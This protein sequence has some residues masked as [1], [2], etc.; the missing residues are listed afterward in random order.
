MIEGGEEQFLINVGGCGWWRFAAGLQYLLGLY[1][2]YFFILP[3]IMDDV[4]F[5]RNE[6]CSKSTNFCGFLTFSFVFITFF[7]PSSYFY[8]V[9]Y[10]I[11]TCH[12]GSANVIKDLSFDYKL[13]CRFTYQFLAT[14]HQQFLRYSLFCSWSV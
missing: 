9:L 10:F 8:S 7:V 14:L 13:Y 3:D 6:I 4:C 1:F 2:F 11:N 12:Y 5:N